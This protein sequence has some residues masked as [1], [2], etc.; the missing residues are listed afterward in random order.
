MPHLTQCCKAWSGANI[1]WEICLKLNLILSWIRAI[2]HL[3]NMENIHILQEQFII[4][5][6]WG[7]LI[8]LTKNIKY[9]VNA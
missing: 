3:V 6:F 7:M 8:I 9:K 2:L 5:V 4:M 1:S